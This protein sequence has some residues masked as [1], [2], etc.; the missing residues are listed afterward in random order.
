[1]T[2]IATILLILSILLAS[3]ICS[4][5]LTYCVSETGNS[6]VCSQ[7][8]YPLMWFV[9]RTEEI[10]NNSVILFLRGNH[11]LYS[12]GHD[13]A[14]LNFSNKHNLTL[15]GEGTVDYHGNH[16]SVLC[17]GIQSAFVFQL[18]TNIQIHEL[19][20]EN[21]GDITMNTSAL[22]FNATSNISLTHVTIR[23]AIVYSLTVHGVCG[24]Y[25]QI[26]N[27]IFTLFNSTKSGNTLFWFDSKTCL[28]LTTLLITNS[29]FA[30]RQHQ[31]V[32][33]NKYNQ[34]KSGLY[35]WIHQPAVKVTI[36]NVTAINGT[37]YYNGGNIKIDMITFKSNPSNVLISDC[38]IMNGHA[39]EG[40]GV[41]I[42]LS[43]Q[44]EKP[45]KLAEVIIVNTTFKGNKA[46]ESGGALQLLAKETSAKINI[47]LF[48]CTFQHNG[49]KIGGATLFNVW[50]MPIFLQHS[51]ESQM[52]VTFNECNM[53]SNYLI[54]YPD[55]VNDDGIVC[56]NTVH[57]TT[58]RNTYF[59]NNNGTALLLVESSVF[60][61]DHVTFRDNHAAYGAAIR[62]CE[63]SMFF[64]RKGSNVIFE[65]NSA[66]IAGGAI[67]AGN[68]CLQRTP[69]CFYQPILTSRI[70]FSELA[71]DMSLSFQNNS[72]MIAGD[73]IYGGSV[74]NCYIYDA[75]KI[76]SINEG[77]Y[78]SVYQ[79]IFHFS[80][81]TVS[82]VTSDPVRVCICDP[83]TGQPNCTVS[84]I[85]L[86]EKF[87]GEIFDL[88]LTAVGQA[89]GTVP[90]LINVSSS[91]AKVVITTLFNNLPLTTK[92]Q[93]I[94]VAVFS[95][96]NVTATFNMSLVQINPVNEHSNYYYKSEV[97]INVPIADCPW[98]FQLNTTTNT[99]GCHSTI[100][101]HNRN[102]TTECNITSLSVRK[103]CNIWINCITET[104]EN[105][106]VSSEACN[107]VQVGTECENCH[108]SHNDCPIFTPF[109]LSDQ[110][111]DGREG[112]LCGSCKANYSY[113]LGPPK[114]V[115]IQGNCTVSQSVLLVFAFL[116]AGI[117]LIS[118][119]AIFNFTVAEGTVTGILFYA[120]CV[121]ANSELFY[122][123]SKFCQIVRVLI[124]W[125]NLDLGFQVCFFSGMTVY[126]KLWLE[127]G[128]I[129]YLLFLGILIV[130]LSRRF[131]CFTKLIG[132]NVV[133]VLS[134]VVI[135]VFPKLVKNSLKVFRC[136]RD[137]FY[138]SKYPQI[139]LI[140]SED[141]TI[142]C[143]QGKHM[144]LFILSVFCFTTAFLYTLCL[145]SIQCL[146]QGSSWYPLRWV[147]KLRPFFDANTGPCRDNYRFW[148]GLVLLFKLVVFVSS[149]L[150]DNYNRLVFLAGVCLFMFFL[151]FIFPRGVYKKWPLNVIEFSMYVL[152]GLT[153]ALMIVDK[154]KSRK[155]N[156][157][158]SLTIATGLF[159]LVMIYH[160][161]KTVS[162]T[163]CW[164]KIVIWIRQKR[165]QAKQTNNK[166]VDECSA[167]LRPQRLTP[168]TQFIDLRE[169]LLEDD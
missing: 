80:P 58:I 38:H 126:I 128:F 88:N 12:R 14:V 156:A 116:F 73:A 162:K 29:I 22:S 145:L 134:T 42:M 64:L 133:P 23:G 165:A 164:K 69:T 15:R 55:Q 157:K 31:I 101:K 114:C 81:Q 44:K 112:R 52:Q 59:I 151:I 111:I 62:L 67:Y 56:L 152:L 140:W 105:N 150:L 138:S 93:T 123:G 74:E 5:S 43:N 148:P 10:A 99:C 115:I 113:S 77:L 94:N 30:S 129:A 20:F 125:L 163:R 28:K 159:L 85:T 131:V 110:C 154:Q 108:C 66:T 87:P 37:A 166:A 25:I 41:Y 63:V 34:N 27:S 18:S 70:T 40:G 33:L 120:N 147:N 139:P 65:G 137:N 1:M 143:L 76:N 78:N 161:Y 36:Q 50:K 98:I 144:I 86:S 72:A 24:G 51:A 54:S 60:F 83:R 104:V 107:E 167:L 16:S 45:S 57:K 84:T 46:V 79:C 153:S 82:M 8:C 71:N 90:A 122:N 97:N 127:F 95:K 39:H 142:D 135:F 3:A 146:E 21:C 168:A 132:R 7:K 96:P 11:S 61:K 117:F 160:S 130:L 91:S 119:L 35:I 75:D 149:I 102:K 109:N 68:Q 49:A 9:N 6:T 118:F 4:C 141:Q 121:H 13:K 100:L 136:S 103:T 92:C 19:T 2:A 47:T 17:K 155:R 32:S 158:T 89:Q 48:R 53:S 106:S 124:S 26:S 169:P